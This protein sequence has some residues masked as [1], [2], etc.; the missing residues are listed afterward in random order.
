M[1]MDSPVTVAQRRISGMYKGTTHFTTRVL[2]DS[3]S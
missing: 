2:S 1:V 3:F